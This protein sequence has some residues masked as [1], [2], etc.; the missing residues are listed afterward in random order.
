[1]LETVAIYIGYQSIEKSWL[2][3]TLLDKDF[4][5]YKP[6][7]Y[8]ISTSQSPSILNKEIKYITSPYFFIR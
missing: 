6:S 7:Y 3:I 5:S 4:M 2:H 1:M 8:R